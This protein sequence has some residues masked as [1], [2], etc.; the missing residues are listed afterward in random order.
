MIEKYVMSENN[1]PDGML[2]DQDLYKISFE[3]NIL[4]LSFNIVL[5]EEE[6]GNIEFAKE[7]FNYKKCHIKCKLKD[8]DFTDVCLHTLVN[9]HNKGKFQYLSINEFVEL[10]NK[11]IKNN[12][13][14]GWRSIQ[15]LYTYTSPNIHCAKIELCLGEIKYKGMKHSMCTIKLDTDEIYYIWE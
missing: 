3:N 2:H 7:Y 14:K 9:R 15:Y 5:S 4:T 11:E 13:V 6:Y 1:I 12:K 10:A 8:N